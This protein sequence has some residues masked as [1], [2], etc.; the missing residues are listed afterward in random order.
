MVLP[1]FYETELISIKKFSTNVILL[2]L[3]LPENKNLNFK[4]ESYE[5]MLGL[6]FNY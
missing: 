6:L 5:G 1:Q 4:Q 2:E 3:K